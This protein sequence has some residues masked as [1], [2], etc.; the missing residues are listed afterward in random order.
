MMQKLLHDNAC[1][2]LNLDCD[3]HPQFT[4]TAARVLADA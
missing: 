3:G 4:G 2:Y 1:E